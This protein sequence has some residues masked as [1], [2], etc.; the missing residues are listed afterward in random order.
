MSKIDELLEKMCPEGVEWKRIGD[1]CKR[2]VSGGTPSTGRR[3]FYGGSIPWLRTQEV[4]WSD[5]YSTSVTITEDG[6]RQSSAT[7]I[8]ENCVIVAMYGATAAK[9][10]V[11]RI[12][13]TTN[14]ACCNLQI[15][16]STADFKYVY[17]WLCNE[18][19]NLKSLGEGSQSNINGQKVKNYPIPIP[20]LPIQEEIVKILDSFTAL[21]AE[22]EAE[23]E[24][25][26]AQYEYYRNKLL[27]FEGEDVEWKSLGEVGKV[28][29]CKRI[30]KDQTQSSGDI[31]FYKIGTFGK[32]PDAFI[33]SAL[34]SDFKKRF[35]FPKRGD[36]L[37]SA[38]GTIGRTVVYD[39][40][41]AY[42]QDSNIVWIDNDEKFVLNKFLMH[43]Y[44]VVRWQTDTGGTISRLYTDN[45]KKARIPIPPLAEQERIVTILDQFDALVNDISKGLPAE[46]AARRQQY[47]H[48]RN[49]LLTFKQKQ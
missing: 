21:E 13:L 41:D 35:S 28:C 31:P 12:S 20:P 30:F 19:L 49:R 46:I 9:V 43:Y 5:I 4:N 37:I 27:A 38:S 25:R 18:Y 7:W 29:M 39:G 40:E 34:Y 22:L 24:A 17:Y 36:V 44:Q 26:S 3:E 42:F 47:E 16:E 8:P 45:L 1:I 14:Q 23:L 6:L 11:N 33:S 2:I 15:N 32:K 10:A 48:Y